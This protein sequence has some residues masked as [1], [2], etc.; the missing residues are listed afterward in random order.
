MNNR[1]IKGTDYDAAKTKYWRIYY[2]SNNRPFTKNISNK[3]TV[4]VLSKKRNLKSSENP[5]RSYKNSGDY[6]ITLLYYPG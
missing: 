6:F 3:D 2:R 4:A 1:D 5:H